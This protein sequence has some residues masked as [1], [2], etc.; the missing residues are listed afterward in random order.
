M[1]AAFTGTFPIADKPSHVYPQSCNIHPEHLRAR[2]H[3]RLYA[4]DQGAGGKIGLVLPSFTPCA[5]VA[6]SAAPMITAPKG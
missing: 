1:Q 2:E 4:L 5:S 6:R 3:Q